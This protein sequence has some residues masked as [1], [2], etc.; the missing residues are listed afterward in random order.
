[1]SSWTHP[2][3]SHPP[4]KLYTKIAGT[5]SGEG[6]E[7]A[8]RAAIR[9]AILNMKLAMVSGTREEIVYLKQKGA[10]GKRAPS[11]S[12]LSAPD[13]MRLLRAFKQDHIA[14]QL[15]RSVEN[16]SMVQDAC[17]HLL[18]LIPGDTTSKIEGPDLGGHDPGHLDFINDLPVNVPGTPHFNEAEFAPEYIYKPDSFDPKPVVPRKPR[19]PK[20]ETDSSKS[21]RSHRAKTTSKKQNETSEGS[22]CGNKVQAEEETGAKGQSD[23]TKYVGEPDQHDSRLKHEVS[24]PTLPSKL[25]PVKRCDDKKKRKLKYNDGWVTDHIFCAPLK[26]CK[27]SPIEVEVSKS[28]FEFFRVS[29][30]KRN[31]STPKKKKK[32]LGNISRTNFVELKFK[33]GRDTPSS[34]DEST[35]DSDGEATESSGKVTVLKDEQATLTHEYTMAERHEM[36]PSSEESVDKIDIVAQDMFSELRDFTTERVACL[37]EPFRSLSASPVTALSMQWQGK[38]KLFENGAIAIPAI[39]EASAPVKLLATLNAQSSIIVSSIV[40][41][42]DEAKWIDSL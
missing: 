27:E 7:Q 14:E 38:K 34:V 15:G 26:G 10:L 36:S 35:S 23:P 22:V 1:M 37:E 19:K 13:M 3:S 16:I 20:T 6:S 8:H 24:T 42:D 28:E 32:G 40:E 2:T 9:Q 30:G 25:S 21:K 12:L 17:V 11:C 33:D 41:G 39:K 4:N 5:G 29:M 18:A 31:R